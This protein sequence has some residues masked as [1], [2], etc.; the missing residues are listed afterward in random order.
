M[1]TGF[2]KLTSAALAT[3]PGWFDKKRGL[4]YG[5]FAS[6]S[7][8]G[9]VIFPI[10]ISRLISSIGY[11]WAMRISAF[12]ILSLLVVATL[13]IRSR[14]PPNPQVVTAQQLLSPFHEPAF[15]LLMAGIAVF[16]FGMFVPINYLVVEAIS[17]GMRYSIAQYLVSIFNAARYAN[18]IL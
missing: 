15:L 10:M 9:G 3:L 2:T 17:S 13:T 1:L 14:F 18:T 11:G 4:A 8:I 7:S 5:I 6:G 12:L 16:T